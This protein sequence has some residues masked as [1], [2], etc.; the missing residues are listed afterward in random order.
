MPS[1]ILVLSG[2][3]ACGK[4]TIAEYLQIEYGYTRIAFA[5]AVR[6]I[7][8]IIE[9]GSERDRLFLAKVGQAL[10]EKIPDFAVSALRHTLKKIQGPVVIEDVRFPAEYDFC[11][12][13]GA[14][15]VRLEINRDTQILRL[16]GRGDDI[17]EIEQ[18]IDCQDEMQFEI[19][20][21]WDIQISA[22]G[23]FK[24]IAAHLNKKAEGGFE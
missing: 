3:R 14:V 2:P 4:S 12:T 13:I 6:S 8:T 15:M 24:D 21:K 19:P 20:P 1:P 9:P 16:Q 5:D 22:V 7:A 11:R 10:R 18:L 17:G 23:D